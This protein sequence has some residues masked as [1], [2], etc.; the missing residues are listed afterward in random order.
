M[1]EVAPA[2]YDGELRGI[3]LRTC[4]RQKLQAAAVIE[5]PDIRS[6]GKPCVVRN[7]AAR[8]ILTEPAGID[9]EAVRGGIGKHGPCGF[10]AF[11]QNKT[12]QLG[13]SSSAKVHRAQMVK[14]TLV[15]IGDNDPLWPV[16]PPGQ[17]PGEGTA[18]A[19][20]TQTHDVASRAGEVIVG[21]EFLRGE[22]RRQGVLG[23]A[24]EPAIS[25]GNTREFSADGAELVELVEQV[26]GGRKQTHFV[27]GHQGAPVIR[28][29]PDLLHEVNV[30]LGCGVD[31]QVVTDQRARRET[32][33]I[34]PGRKDFHDRRF[35]GAHPD[36]SHITAH[37]RASAGS[38]R[39]PADTN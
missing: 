10:G 19:A 21:E 24:D 9:D 8:A 25:L 6:F 26:V 18:G 16:G 5:L 14:S 36:K 34:G 20:G 3:R 38:R 35:L 1:D 4:L 27:G 12:D 30:L 15:R 23:V 33:N 32:E 31:R 28:V 13:G 7:R 11:D 37:A 2:V 17:I 39:V 29:V 22:P